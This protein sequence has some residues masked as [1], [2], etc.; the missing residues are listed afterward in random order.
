MN[1]L[2]VKRRNIGI[3]LASTMFIFFR[4]VIIIPEK[5]FNISIYEL[6]FSFDLRALIFILLIIIFSMTSALLITGIY[7]QKQDY[8]IAVCVLILT[9][10][11]LFVAVANCFVLFSLAISFLFIF[12]I[13]YCKNRKLLMLLLP[14]FGLINTMLCPGAV[15]TVVPLILTTCFISNIYDNQKSKKYIMLFIASVLFSVIGYIINLTVLQKKNNY[16]EFFEKYSFSEL[17]HHIGFKYQLGILNC[18]PYIAI[19]FV[20]LSL[21]M[22]ERKKK[23]NKSAKKNF[24]KSNTDF[25]IY[26]SMILLLVLNFI[27]AIIYG[28]SMNIGYTL[29][30]SLLIIILIT[31][32]NKDLCAENAAKKMMS[33]VKKHMSVFILL[34]FIGSFV[35]VI[36]VRRFYNGHSILSYAVE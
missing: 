4:T 27:G 8:F 13:I 10:S 14:V 12:G 21:Y 24:N 18:I 16:I 3:W 26:N 1:S 19:A 29:N 31:L 17:T 25:Y 7:N 34:L 33:F 36:L 6:D 11:F 35:G 15:F 9:D 5:Y 30:I 22:K 28:K 2:K 23:I 32:S 20:F